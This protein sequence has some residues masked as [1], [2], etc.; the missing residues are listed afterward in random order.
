MGTIEKISITVM[1]IS[2]F[3]FFYAILWLAIGLIAYEIVTRDV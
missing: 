3:G 2:I 1:M